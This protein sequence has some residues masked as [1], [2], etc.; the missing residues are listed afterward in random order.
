MLTADFICTVTTPTW[1]WPPVGVTVN[2]MR[3]STTW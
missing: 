2:A 3:P 1:L